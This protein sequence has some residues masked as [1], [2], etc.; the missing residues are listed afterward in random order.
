MTGSLK[1]PTNQLTFLIDTFAMQIPDEHIQQQIEAYLNQEMTD[2]ERAKFEKQIHENQELH[3]EVEMQEAAF[4]AIKR[5]RM[6]ALKAG[7]NQ[8]NISLWSTG[9]MEMAKVAAISIGVISGVF[10][11]YWLLEKEPLKNSNQKE[12]VSPIAPIKE[13]QDEKDILQS[14]NLPLSK[15]SNEKNLPLPDPEKTKQAGSSNNPHFYKSKPTKI[16]DDIIVGPENIGANEPAEPLAKGVVP[17]AAKD[18]NNPSDG[19]SERTSLESVHPEVIIKKDNKNIFHYQFSDGKL[20]LYADFNDQLYEVIELNQNGGK[21]IFFC[22]NNSFYPL[23]PGQHEIAP[24][25]EVKDKSLIQLLT[26]YQK[27]KN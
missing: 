1:L 23:N 22:Y 8:V 18:L 21:Q 19:I 16:T 5:E 17:F 4:E 13:S 6:L 14:S 15:S 12:T 10:G 26:A 24:L 2:L 3:D 20:I 27:R 9:L 11:A 7:L 25:M